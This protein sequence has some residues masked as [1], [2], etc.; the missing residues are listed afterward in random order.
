MAFK[1]SKFNMPKYNGSGFAY[2]YEYTYSY[3]TKL[4]NA[5]IEASP[6]WSLVTDIENV[7]TNSGIEGMH[8]LQLKSNTSNKYLRIW[9]FGGTVYSSMKSVESVTTSNTLNIYTG[10]LFVQ[11]NDSWQSYYRFGGSCEIYFGV[12]S[13]P[14]DKD[15]GKNLHLDIPMFGLGNDITRDPMVGYYNNGAYCYGATV[16]VI[17]DG[18]MFGVIKH[19]NGNWPMVFYAPDMFICANSSDTETSGVISSNREGANFYLGNDSSDGHTMSCIFN[20]ADKSHDFN[21]MIQAVNNG[22]VATRALTVENSTKMACMPLSVWMYPYQYSGSTMSAVV[23]GIGF[24]G[25]INTDYIRSV[26]SHVLPFASKGMKYGSGNWLCV[27]AGTL[28]CWDDSNTSPFEAAVE[29]PSSGAGAD[30]GGK[31]EGGEG[32]PIGEDGG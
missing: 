18:S 20:A 28:V 26:D 25:W 7:S 3:I 22:R 30:G 14:I 32:K 5:F 31:D 15:P 11:N 12:A 27:D 23:D 1:S 19:L 8:T 17:T 10:N 24:K 6:T 4:K 13:S 16:S 21:G 9:V 2:P 29:N